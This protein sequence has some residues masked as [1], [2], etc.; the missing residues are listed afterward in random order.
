MQPNLAAADPGVRAAALRWL[1]R[2]G[3]PADAAAVAAL[4][5][6]RAEFDDRDE[7]SDPPESARTP[8]RL[9]AIESLVALAAPGAYREVFDHALADADL[10]IRAAATLGA[11]TGALLARL[12]VE[13]DRGVRYRIAVALHPAD[14]ALR[15][16]EE[17]RAGDDF[18]AVAAGV[19]LDAA[20]EA[21]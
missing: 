10:R 4:V 3:E 11:S 21:D 5:E 1:A 14:V 20:A 8:V 19:V 18:A 16:L 17:L 15:V 13:E 2:H 12:A 9:I 6:D 7:C